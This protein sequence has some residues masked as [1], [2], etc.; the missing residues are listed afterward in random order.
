M[1]KEGMKEEKKGWFPFLGKEK[2]EPEKQESEMK[3]KFKEGAKKAGEKAKEIGKKAGE[4]GKKGLKWLGNEAKVVPVRIEKKNAETKRQKAM[5]ML[6]EMMFEILNNNPNQTDLIIDDD[7][8]NILK[9][10]RYC[11]ETIDEC[12]KKLKMTHIGEDE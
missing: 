10:I 2:K 12:D 5:E 11:D 8:R 6:G 1:G 3:E 9:E 4:A 7:I